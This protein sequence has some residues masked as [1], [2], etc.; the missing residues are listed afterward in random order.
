MS[1]W[2]IALVAIVT[3]SVVGSAQAN[4]ISNPGFETNEVFDV[5]VPNTFGDWLGDDAS[6]V[7]GQR[8]VS[9]RSGNRML[10]FDATGDGASLVGTMAEMYQLVD[11]TASQADGSHTASLSAWFNRSGG[12]D[13]K[14]SV[15]VYAVQGSPA[16]AHNKLLS[17][18][19]LRAD[20]GVVR[21]DSN[22]G[23]WQQASASLL[24]PS[25]TDYLMVR[26]AA[27][28]DGTNDFVA[29][30]FAG[31]YVDDVSLQVTSPGTGD[32][33]DDDDP[34]IEDDDDDDTPRAKLIYNWAD[35]S[36]TIETITP[37]LITAFALK[38][39]EGNFLVGN[40]NFP[41]D[42]LTNA[43]TATQISYA[44][45]DRDGFG[46][47]VALGQILAAGIDPN[48]ILDMITMES[49][50][51]YVAPDFTGIF[52]FEMEVINYV[53]EPF[54]LSLVAVGGLLAIRRKR[55]S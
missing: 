20:S 52:D 26:V 46:G 2:L 9:P 36:V 8:G 24:I 27:T 51:F 17:N 28:E 38:S 11:I 31:H 37:D 15:K 49:A 19:F 47:T 16:S 41:K 22:P 30:E 39:S 29:P 40:V 21:T 5:G 3:L 44:D 43:D 42:F 14:F 45:L 7:G 55:R 1:K 25:G 33:D 32:D 50:R 4:L 23:T 48:D 53:P 6:R 35:G 54:T 10:R 13:R 34:I 12:D 18:D